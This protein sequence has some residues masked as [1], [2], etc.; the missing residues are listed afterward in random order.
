MEVKKFCVYKNRILH[1]IKLAVVLDC[2]FLLLLPSA[3]EVWGRCRFYMG[4][5]GMANVPAGV[6][7]KTPIQ[8]DCIFYTLK[9][10]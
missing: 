8:S 1:R 5:G 4:A 10:L 9:L 2:F 6:R 7:K 3:A